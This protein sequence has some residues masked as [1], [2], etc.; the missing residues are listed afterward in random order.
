MQIAINDGHA[1]ASEQSADWRKLSQQLRS[2][3]RS[4]A[5]R[6]H[7]TP[8]PRAGFGLLVA[9]GLG[10]G[11]AAVFF[12]IHQLGLLVDS[13]VFHLLPMLSAFVCFFL[14]LLLSKRPKTW[15]EQIDSQLAA[16]EPI[17]KDAYRKLQ[18]VVRELGSLELQSVEEW[19][20]TEQHALKIASGW[21][22]AAPD[23]F[24]N[25]KV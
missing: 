11:M 22:K 13:P 5:Q 14:V 9:T 10:V 6:E 18:S 1:S 21:R 2:I 15:T 17:D 12:G 20:H 3:E 8:G 25:K 19:I 4:L 7:M 23:G 24:L 16:Y